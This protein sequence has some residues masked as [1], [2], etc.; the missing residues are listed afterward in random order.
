MRN[1]ELD[2]IIDRLKL[3]LPKETKAASFSL[4]SKNP[5]KLTVLRES[6]LYRIYDLSETIQ[7]L[8][9][10]DKYIPSILLVRAC[11]ET[12]ALLFS[13]SERLNKS[14][15]A[16]NFAELSQF[17]DRAILGNRLK[18]KTLDTIDLQSVNVLTC[19]EALEKRME[20][21]RDF[22]DIF[23]EY[24]HPNMHGVVGS[25]SKF[26]PDDNTT[27]YGIYDKANMLKIAIESLVIIL[28]EFISIYETFGENILKY[29]NFLKSDKL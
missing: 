28:N 29:N 8:I 13:T 5:F 3:S 25:Y 4:E 22:Y 11:I 27:H 9:N 19:I 1:N 16:N 12:T 24:A 14:L 15:I 7:L 2:I 10:N 20:S 17:L 21:L 23:S 26:D 18:N 6:L